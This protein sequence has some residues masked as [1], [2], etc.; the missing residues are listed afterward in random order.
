MAAE[1]KHVK[2]WGNGYVRFSLRDVIAIV[3]FALMLAGHY[4]ITK[5]DI[6]SLQKNDV[7]IVESVDS[8]RVEVRGALKLTDTT[9]YLDASNE[10]HKRLF[11]LT[12]APQEYRPVR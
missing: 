10:I 4:Y 12:G 3:T 7:I 9:R 5:G 2:S 8:L 11:E 6:R 1:V